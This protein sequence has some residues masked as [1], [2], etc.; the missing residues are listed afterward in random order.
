MCIYICIFIFLLFCIFA[1]SVGKIA[2]LVSVGKKIALHWCCMVCL[3]RPDVAIN[4][5]RFLGVA[6]RVW[7]FGSRFFAS[8]FCPEKP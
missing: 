5:R 2:I 8:D 3:C 6:K 4:G 7:V 1:F